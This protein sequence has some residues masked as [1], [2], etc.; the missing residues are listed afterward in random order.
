MR[1][2]KNDLK[3][4]LIPIEPNTF[5]KNIQIYLPIRASTILSYT[6][7]GNLSEIAEAL[8]LM[9]QSAIYE[10]KAEIRDWVKYGIFIFLA[11]IGLGALYII[12]AGLAGHS[13]PPASIPTTP[14]PQTPP[15]GGEI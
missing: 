8:S 3:H 2:K 11:L 7:R 13:T 10:Q 4:E 12:V 9:R 15:Y 5:L 1:S 14:I 6:M